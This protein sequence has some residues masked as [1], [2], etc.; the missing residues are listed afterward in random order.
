LAGANIVMD[1]RLDA[2]LALGRMH[3]VISELER[4]HFWDVLV[5]GDGEHL[6][7]VRSRSARQSSN[8]SMGTLSGYGSIR[9]DYASPTLGCRPGCSA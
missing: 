7:L 3:Q 5:L 8:A 4:G 9:G 1:D 2:H 6:V